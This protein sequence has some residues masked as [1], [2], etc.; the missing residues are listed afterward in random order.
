[1]KITIAKPGIPSGEAV[2]HIN[3]II[4]RC[5][6][7][8]GTSYD[9]DSDDDYRKPGDHNY[10]ILYG[11]G[12]PLSVVYLFVPTSVEAEVYAFTVPEQRRKGHMSTLLREVAGEVKRRSVPSLLFVCDG[13]SEDGAA[14]LKHRGASYDFSE[15]SMILES[16]VPAAER[17][18]IQI[19][20]VREEDREEL[21]RINGEAFHE[22]RRT[23]EETIGLFYTSDKRDFYAVI[24]EGKVVGMIG[25]YLEENRDYIHGFAMDASFRGRG[26][27]QQALQLMIDK[28][29][30]ADTS[31]AVVLE[32]ES[33]NERALNLYKRCGFRLVSRFD[34]YREPL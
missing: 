15:F 31:R 33:E 19:R 12:V 6:S 4:G 1:M 7:F 34:Y 23:V 25:R 24:H 3:Q 14:F 2:S 22:E 18:D 28:C 26:W 13:N 21:I 29:R 27:G 11:D 32:V 9:F 10:F 8:D 16:P 20:P 30:I 17:H 5:N